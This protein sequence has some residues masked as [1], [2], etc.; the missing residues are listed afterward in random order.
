MAGIPSMFFSMMTGNMP[1]L[2]ESDERMCVS[3]H[4]PGVKKEDYNAI[5]TE[6]NQLF[7]KCKTHDRQHVYMGGLKLPDNFDRTRA[8]Y[9]DWEQNG[10]FKLT[11]PLVKRTNILTNDLMDT[12]FNTNGCTTFYYA[13]MDRSIEEEDIHVAMALRAKMKSFTLYEKETLESIYIEG[14]TPGLEKMEV[15][16]EAV[17]VSLNMPGWG[18]RLRTWGAIL[19]NTTL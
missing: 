13:M 16:S 7:V 15:T 4:M 3:L 8:F 5:I 17:C 1:G 18:S 6:D 11:L 12:F 10:T 9:H 14:S 19:L 2:K